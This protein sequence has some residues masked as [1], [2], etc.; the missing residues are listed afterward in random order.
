MP[1]K[2]IGYIRVPFHPTPKSLARNSHAAA[3]SPLPVRVLPVGI[4]T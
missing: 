3:R 4:L 2:D 1:G